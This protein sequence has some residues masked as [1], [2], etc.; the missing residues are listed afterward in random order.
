MLFPVLA[1]LGDKREFLYLGKMTVLI[2]GMC[3]VFSV[4]LWFQ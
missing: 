4:E 1:H 2:V 3:I